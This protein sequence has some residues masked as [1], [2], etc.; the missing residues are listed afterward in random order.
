MIESKGFY[1]DPEVRPSYYYNRIRPF[2]L[3]RRALKDKN[4]REVWEEMVYVFA[5]KDSTRKRLG[6]NV[7]FVQVVRG[8]YLA[9][10][11]SKS[12]IT[13]VAKE[14]PD[15]PLV[16]YQAKCS[17]VTLDRKRQPILCRPTPTP[18]P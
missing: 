12:Y 17:M 15:G 1:A 6:L 4:F 8:Y 14:K 18:K 10:P 16:E 2:S 13:F 5:S 3:E 11:R 9:S 7:E